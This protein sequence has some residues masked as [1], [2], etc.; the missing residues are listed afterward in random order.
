MSGNP[1]AGPLSAGGGPFPDSAVVQITNTSGQIM[2]PFF[3]IWPSPPT[4]WSV[5]T[6]NIPALGG[7]AFGCATNIPAGGQGSF[8]VISSP[9]NG[10]AATPVISPGC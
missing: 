2:G 9:S 4:G 7:P 3:A 6:L 1:A 10:D 8:E 5:Y